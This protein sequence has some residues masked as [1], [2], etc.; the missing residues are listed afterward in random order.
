MSQECWKAGG[1]RSSVESSQ[2]GSYLLIIACTGM[3]YSI[4]KMV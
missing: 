2:E 4:K 3:F 1:Q